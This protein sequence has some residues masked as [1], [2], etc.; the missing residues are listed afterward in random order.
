MISHYAYLLSGNI[1]ARSV[2]ESYISDI[3]DDAAIQNVLKHPEEIKEV[4]KKEVDFNGD[5]DLCLR[6]TMQLLFGAVDPKSEIDKVKAIQVP[7]GICGKI[8]NNYDLLWFCKSCQMTPNSGLCQ[9]CYSNSCHDGHDAFFRKGYIGV[10]DCGDPDAWKPSGFCTK[11][12]GYDE[13]KITTDLLPAHTRAVAYPIFRFLAK[14]AN[15]AALELRENPAAG[16][17]N[18]QNCLTIRGIMDFFSSFTTISAIFAKLECQAL[19]EFMLTPRPGSHQCNFRTFLGVAEEAE[20]QKNRARKLE[21]DKKTDPTATA[22]RCGCKVLENLIK[23]IH[24]V[25]EATLTVFCEYLVKMTKSPLLKDLLG[26]GLLSNYRVVTTESS[27]ARMQQEEAI[28]KVALQLFTVD[29]LAFKYLQREDCQNA[30]L[31]VA[32]ELVEQVKKGTPM[33]EQDIYIRLFLLKRDIKYFTQPK[34]MQYLLESTYFFE[35]MLSILKELEFLPLYVPRDSHV[36]NES[37]GGLRM[38]PYFDK[39]FGVIC[40]AFVENTDYS[41]VDYCRR[42]GTFFRGLLL[43]QAEK[44]K[45]IMKEKPGAMYC[46]TQIHRCFYQFF[47]TYLHVH[48]A[49]SGKDYGK[50]PLEVTRK[51]LRNLA[52]GLLTEKDSDEELDS[53]IEATL[54]VCLTPLLFFIEIKAKKWVN[55]GEYMD[56]IMDFYYHRSG[57][58]YYFPDFGLVQLLVAMYD[59][60]H[61]HE[62]FEYLLKMH[63]KEEPLAQ[64]YAAIS[65]VQPAAPP[66]LDPQKLTTIIEGLIHLMCSLSSNDAIGFLP[67]VRLSAEIAVKRDYLGKV[68]DVCARA[69]DYYFKRQAIHYAMAAQNGQFAYHEFLKS[70]PKKFSKSKS[71][72][73]LIQELCISTKNAKRQ[74]L[75]SAKPDKLCLFDPYYYPTPSDTSESLDNCAD[76]FKKLEKKDLFDPIFGGVK[77]AES[78]FLPLADMF[79]ERIMGPALVQLVLSVI[80]KREEK[81]LTETLKMGAFK[82]LFTF[83]TLSQRVLAMKE[84]LLSAMAPHAKELFSE[85]NSRAGANELQ[86]HSYSRLA[87][88]LGALSPELRELAETVVVAPVASPTAT[89]AKKKQMKIMEEFKSKQQKFLYS[90]YAQV[91]GVV[92]TENSDIVCA[93]CRERVTEATAKDKPYGKLTFADPSM[94]LIQAKK[95]EFAELKDIPAAEARKLLDMSYTRKNGEGLRMFSCNHYAHE[96][97]YRQFKQTEGNGMALL[98]PSELRDFFQFCPLCRSPCTCVI[99]TTVPAAASPEAEEIAKDV[100]HKIGDKLFGFGKFETLPPLKFYEGIRKIIQYNINMVDLTGAHTLLDGIESLRAF[101]QYSSIYAHSKKHDEKLEETLKSMENPRDGTLLCDRSRSLIDRLYAAFVRRGTPELLPCEDT[102]KAILEEYAQLL[103]G[104]LFGLALKLQSAEKIT[105]E[106]MVETAKDHREELRQLSTKFIRKAL[107]AYCVFSCDEKT[108]SVKAAMMEETKMWESANAWLNFSGVIDQVMAEGK[109]NAEAQKLLQN[110]VKLLGEKIARIYELE[111]LSR[112][113][114]VKLF[115]LDPLYTKMILGHYQKPC[116]ECKGHIKEKALCLGCGTVVCVEFL[117]EFGDVKK[118]CPGFERH[119]VECLGTS[120]LFLRMS[121]GGIIV[122]YKRMYTQLDSPYLT[123]FGESMTVTRSQDEDFELSQTAFHELEDLV[124]HGRLAFIVLTKLAERFG[125]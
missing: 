34:T 109:D 37:E 117:Q 7:I 104:I 57:T 59:G 25:D 20:F 86:T 65:G 47:A 108:E 55:Y 14:T 102:K 49:L 54:Q 44:A 61:K 88:S 9:E 16:P 116:A 53:L 123:K 27:F 6:K 4:L 83:A 69:R 114:A 22:V 113:L 72:E 29:E 42:I 51:D 78:G 2:T 89:D 110:S 1:K 64:L 3:M 26:Y 124:L 70:L 30:I 48:M 98:L 105:L 125:R 95:R 18:V 36:A 118:G 121:N 8:I 90:H 81:V 11:H 120:G 73:T 39:Y 100:C 33:N 38:Q 79:A 15:R 119:C 63:Q 85:I 12:K 58:N 17:S 23:V 35:R 111:L 21:R 56:G 112:S 24:I 103:R 94:Q 28:E 91:Q 67:L 115:P 43:A 82:L 87:H 92:R 96:A 122:H 76:A 107:A 19:N 99:P 40:K 75:F 97:C 74:L 84:P 71:A 60:P 66:T 93:V 10:C 106:A 77:C 62:L 68:K 52:K 31:G 13:T 5:V 32:Q 46:S 45:S 41:N 50:L 80:Q 101:L